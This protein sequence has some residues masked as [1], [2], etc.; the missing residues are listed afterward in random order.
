VHVVV[1]ASEPAEQV[2]VSLKAWATRRLR[3]AGLG[4]G[5]TWAR[6]GSTRYV[7]DEMG[8]TNVCEYVID[9]Q[10]EPLL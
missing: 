7:W 9:L 8:L 3:E 6:H 5:K 10:G 2:M 4:A 1:A